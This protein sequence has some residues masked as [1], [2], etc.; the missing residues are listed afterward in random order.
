VETVHAQ[1]SPLAEMDH[2]EE[3]R[4]VFP[5]QLIAGHALKITTVVPFQ[6]CLV[7]WEMSP[8]TIVCAKRTQVAAPS[9]GMHLVF[10]RF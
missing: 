5:A 1:E 8:A 10:L 7:A 9:P 4:P 2:V 3:M 6:H